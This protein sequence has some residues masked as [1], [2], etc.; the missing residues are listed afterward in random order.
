MR[1]SKEE[2]A[3]PHWHFSTAKGGSTCGLLAR[4]AQTTSK[5]D[6]LLQLHGCRSGT[7]TSGVTDTLPV[8]LLA[9]CRLHAETHAVTR[10]EPAA[11]A[12]RHGPGRRDISLEGKDGGEKRRGET[13]QRQDLQYSSDCS[14][15][16]S[17]VT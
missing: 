14:P 12:I 6:V 9:Q 13:G 8:D 3:P 2:R 10:V 17:T 16:C 1:R 11:E 7:T 15:T 4:R 5:G